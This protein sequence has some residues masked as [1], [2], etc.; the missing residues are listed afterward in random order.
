M[1]GSFFTSSI[2]S[3]SSSLG[4]SGLYRI[5][6][7]ACNK[8]VEFSAVFVTTITP[9]GDVYTLMAVPKGM[10]LNATITVQYVCGA[11]L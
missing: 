5:E 6:F 1:L 3:L 4:G 8:I 10:L 11:Q 2:F 9:V 7:S